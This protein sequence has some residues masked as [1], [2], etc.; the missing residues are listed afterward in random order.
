MA[1]AK[2]RAGTRRIRGAAPGG[3]GGQAGEA[4][5][6]MLGGGPPGGRAGAGY[7]DRRLTCGVPGPYN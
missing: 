2:G 3:E 4:R 7:L 6:A 1:V 5:A